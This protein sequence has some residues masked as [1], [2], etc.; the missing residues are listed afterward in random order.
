MHIKTPVTDKSFLEMVTKQLGMVSAEHGHRYHSGEEMVGVLTEEYL[1]VLDAI[2]ES[3]G[4]IS[5]HVLSELIDI[6]VV[7]VR[8][9]RDYMHNNP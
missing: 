1:E 8:G 9:A 5:S 4:K 6:A 2:R 3:K 7:C